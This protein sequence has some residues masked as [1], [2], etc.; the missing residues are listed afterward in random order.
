MLPVR[1]HEA[2]KANRV[3]TAFSWVLFCFAASY[4]EAQ[5]VPPTAQSITAAIRGKNYEQALQLARQALKAT[6]ND[7]QI[8]TLEGLA[9]QALGKDQSAL[10][11][12]QHALKI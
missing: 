2:M 11:S 5:S 3:K 12:F 8:L 10:A 7:A 1:A 6:P 4:V 9:L